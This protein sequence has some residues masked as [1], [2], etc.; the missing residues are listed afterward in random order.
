MFIFGNSL[1]EG[2]DEGGLFLLFK[3]FWS[4][5]NASFLQNQII[6]IPQ[7]YIYIYLSKLVEKQLS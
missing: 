6:I 5:N 7:L 2:R 1:G 4:M 3:T